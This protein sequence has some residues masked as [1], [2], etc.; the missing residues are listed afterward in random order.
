MESS[1]A[2]FPSFSYDILILVA[3][4]TVDG[5]SWLHKSMVCNF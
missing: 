3:L 2:I 5:A 1:F 4:L